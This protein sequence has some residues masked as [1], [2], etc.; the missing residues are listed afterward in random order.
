MRLYVPAWF[1]HGMMIVIAE[2]YTFVTLTLI[3]VMQEKKPV[4]NIFQSHE[5]IL[6]EFGILFRLCLINFIFILSH[7]INSQ[8]GESNL[9]DFTKRL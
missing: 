5:W 9:G 7:L 8:E 4:P 2:R 6:M 1:K 3:M